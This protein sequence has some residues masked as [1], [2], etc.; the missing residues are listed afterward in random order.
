MPGMRILLLGVAIAWIAYRFGRPTRPEPVDD[1]VLV[2]RVR[3]ALEQLLEHAGSVNIAVHDG[4]VTLTGPVA[5]A[6]LRR[7]K[8]ALR[9]LSGVRA[10]ECRVHVHA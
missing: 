8:R 3:F 7:L 6:E 1:D 2:T 4:R 9:S 10:L 5:Q